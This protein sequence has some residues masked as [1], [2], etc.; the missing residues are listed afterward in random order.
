MNF[1]K[2]VFIRAFVLSLLLLNSCGFFRSI[3]L[4]NIPPDYA[5]TFEEINGIKFIDHPNKTSNIVL[6]LT[7]TQKEFSPYDSIKLKL[8]ISNISLTDTMY[9]ISIH[10]Y[11]YDRDLIVTDSLNKRMKI[12]EWP[13]DHGGVN[14]VDE[15]GRKIKNILVP[16]GTKLGPQK[17]YEA[18][19][20][21]ETGKKIIPHILAN[22]ISMKRENS[23]GTYKAY[24]IQEHEEYDNLKGPIRTEI[25][26]N[27]VNYSVRNY[28]QEETSIRNNAIEVVNKIEE[29][30]GLC[31]ADSLLQEFKLK[32]PESIYSEQ[33]N[34]FIE[35]KK[36]LEKSK[37]GSD[38]KN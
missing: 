5:D 1:V 23:P 28:T 10:Q 37:N 11:Y 16:N 30:E 8:K 17:F 2:T 3:G 32:H 31:L 19:I 13:K 27:I 34:K 24:Y 22:L 38:T 18:I 36:V 33:I 21:F 35:L 4:Y 20:S 7:A 26:S 15:F 6:E 29:I 12:I 25:K 9:I 14:I